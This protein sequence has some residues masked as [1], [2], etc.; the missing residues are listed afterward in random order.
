MVVAALAG[1]YLL[2]VR[3]E[4]PKSALLVA[5]AM[6]M[7]GGAMTFIASKRGARPPAVPWIVVT[8]MTITYAGVLLWVLPALEQ[9][10]VV[11]DVA[12]WVA[13]RARGSDFVASYRLNRWNPAF[14]FYVGRH[15]AMIDAPHEARALFNGP[16]PFYCTM[17]GSAYDEFVAEGAPLRIVYE[18]EGMWATSGRVLWRRKPAPARFV[19]VTR[20]E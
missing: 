17:L 6:G 13:A 5:G 12:R 4:L 9:Q 2:I 18:R 15:V 7:A 11:P 20:R 8:A 19:V 14:R 10:K 16:D 3:L 1:A